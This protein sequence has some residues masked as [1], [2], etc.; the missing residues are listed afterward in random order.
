[1]IE[2]NKNLWHSKRARTNDCVKPRGMEINVDGNEVKFMITKGSEN[3]GSCKLKRMI[4]KAA[5]KVTA[6]N[7]YDNA[8]SL[9]TSALS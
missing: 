9:L 1:M 4:T 5:L 8:G 2:R 3:D 7:V 6:T